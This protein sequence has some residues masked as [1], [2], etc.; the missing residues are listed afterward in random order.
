MAD[1]NTVATLPSHSRHAHIAAGSTGMPKDV[2]AGEKSEGIVSQA[3]DALTGRSNVMQ[4][5]HAQI[6]RAR[7]CSQC[8]RLHGTQHRTQSSPEL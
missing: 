2:R 1:S 8:R 7:N 5:E 3:K 6:D 4:I